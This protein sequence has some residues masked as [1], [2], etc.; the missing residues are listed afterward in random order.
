MFIYSSLLQEDLQESRLLIGRVKV[1]TLS[2]S[3]ALVN[4]STSRMERE[5]PFIGCRTM[6]ETRINEKLQSDSRS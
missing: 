6:V 1:N 5:F 2:D 4:L 3:P